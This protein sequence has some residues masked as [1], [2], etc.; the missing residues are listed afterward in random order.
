MIIFQMLFIINLFD[1]R[2]SVHLVNPCDL[3]QGE[4]ETDK[5]IDVGAETSVVGA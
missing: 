2:V 4:D 5:A 3:I 1:L